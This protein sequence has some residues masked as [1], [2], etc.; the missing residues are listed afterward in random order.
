MLVLLFAGDDKNSQSKDISK[1]GWAEKACIRL[2]LR[3]E[4][5]NLLR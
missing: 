4:T 5:L 2:Y 1:Q 3:K